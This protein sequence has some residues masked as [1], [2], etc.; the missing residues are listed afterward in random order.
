MPA[1]SEPAEARDARAARL[2]Q[3][4]RTWRPLGP[5]IV[6]LVL[7][8][9][10]TV[11]SAVSWIGLGSENQAKFTTFELL[12]L[13]FIALLILTCVHALTRSRVTATRDR[14]IVVN[15]YRRRDLAW[16]QIVTIR[17]PNGAPWVRLDLTDG[18]EISAMG[19]Q[20]SDGA[21]ARDAV[22]FLR[23]VSEDLSDP[24]RST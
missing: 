24:G 3:L 23:R 4:P 11:V 19:I 13:A 17:L 21:R 5:R 10:L 6:A 1:G 14:L 12:T 18:E 15:G 22:R 9:G 20:A 16:A 7:V 8:V 2:A